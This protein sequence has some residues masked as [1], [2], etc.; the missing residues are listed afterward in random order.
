MSATAFHISSIAKLPPVRRNRIIQQLTDAEV[1]ELL[2]DWAF[3][4]R[5]EQVAPPGGW[6]T[7]MF[8]AGRGAGKT[9][10]GAEWVREQVKAGYG[11]IGMIA[12]TA[13]DIRDVMIEGPS[14]ILSVSWQ[15]D[16]DNTG[17]LI[18]LPSYE[19]SKRHKLTW[20]NGATAHGYSAE[21]PERLRGP[22]HDAIWADE[23]AAWKD[24][25][26][27]WDMAMFGLRLGNDPRAMIST[28]PKP[29]P[30]IRALLQD[31]TTKIT[32]ATTYSNKAN[33]AKTFLT[34]IVSKYEGTRLGRQELAG[35][36]LEE[37][38]GALWNRALIE[39]A[40]KGPDG[41]VLTAA[42]AMRRIV[43]AVD[44]AVTAKAESNLTGIVAAGLGQ[45]GRGYVL[46]DVSG[47]YSPDS[48]ARKAVGIFDSLKADRIVAEGNQGGDMVR[49][50]IQSVRPN[51]PV[52][53]VHASRGKQARAEPVAALY[54]QNKVSHV[55]ALAE[56]ED[57]MATWEPLG[58]QPSPDRLDALV[59]AL[60]DLMLHD[61]E[62][63]YVT[64]ER[65]VLA[66]PF[67]IPRH[68]PRVFALDVDRN[69]IA[70]V[71]GAVDRAA[72]T[73]WLYGEYTARRA[74][75]SMHAAAIKDR[76]KSHP[77]LPAWVPGVFDHRAR[78]RSA[79]EGNRIVERL[80]DLNIDLFTVQAD[81]EALVGEVA[82]RL[83][84]KRLRVFSTMPEWLAEYRNYRRD[85]HGEL[86][87]TEDGLMQ[88]TGLLCLSGVHCAVTDRILD[89]ETEREQADLTRDT[90]TGY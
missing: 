45:D 76:C 29:I 53:I 21:E 41:R 52:T 75:L 80:L 79:E 4:A 70:A 71:W 44:P 5:P 56:L 58:D 36:L 9:R 14:G 25:Q 84:A 72:N 26:D 33:L 48:W 88:A 77:D 12:P 35:E 13:G 7:W 68:W 51:I 27:A 59:W 85:K 8:L 50:T 55:G 86:D 32:R 18:G 37:A 47:R 73:V 23:L 38:E 81:T 11:S 66:E 20:A 17:N 34:K 43:V 22:N 46:A 63:A 54:E 19:P 90:V 65:D 60:T 31:P 16:R 78:K 39:R 3:V 89:Q 40:H 6:Q 10:S 42:P 49:Q 62:A 1:E 30:L 24:A 82:T 67:D 83:S 15:H 57:Q 74:D 64:D 28:T 87:D 2:H 69:R 61:G